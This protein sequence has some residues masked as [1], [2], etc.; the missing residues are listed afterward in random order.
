MIRKCRNGM[1]MIHNMV[2]NNT[3]RE[4]NR[5]SAPYFSAYRQIVGAEGMPETIKAINNI[6]NGIGKRV[7]GSKSIGKSS[8]LRTEDCHKYLFFSDEKKTFNRTLAT[9]APTKIIER[10]TVIFPTFSRASARK[11]GH[12][13]GENKRINPDPVARIPGFTKISRQLAA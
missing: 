10:G 11:I 6:G 1:V 3:P 8:S 2:V 7:K 9:K 5:V 13:K 12:V 4:A